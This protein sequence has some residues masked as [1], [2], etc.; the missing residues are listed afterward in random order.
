LRNFYFQT[1]SE[2]SNLNY[3]Q[4]FK[5][6]LFSNCLKSFRTFQKKNEFNF[7]QSYLKKV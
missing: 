3:I 7:I 2:K 4:A 6:G 5:Q 1:A